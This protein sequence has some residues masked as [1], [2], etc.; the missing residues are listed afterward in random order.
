MKLNLILEELRKSYFSH[1]TRIQKMDSILRTGLDPDVSGELWANKE[2][3]KLPPKNEIDYTKSEFGK[4][5]VFI[6]FQSNEI[7][8]K[9]DTGYIFYELV[10]PTQFTSIVYNGE[11][12]SVNEFKNLLTRL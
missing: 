4:G 2:R 7:P 5:S 11:I 3:G 6:M 10:P 12:Y 9:A 1:E 8:E